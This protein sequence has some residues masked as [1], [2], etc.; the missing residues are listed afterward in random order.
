MRDPFSLVVGVIAFL[1]GGLTVLDRTEAVHVDG[2]V[3]FAA[4]WV[5][6]ALLGL[7]VSALR[8]RGRQEAGPQQP[9]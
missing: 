2:A 4:F 5:A 7:A 8:L 6:L 3:A 1:L 9:G